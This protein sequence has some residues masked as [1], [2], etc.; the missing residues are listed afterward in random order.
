MKISEKI[1]QYR[2]LVIVI[3]AFI[4]IIFMVYLPGVE[5]D[6]DIKSQLPKDM[7]SRL[8]TDKIDSLFG[9]TELLMVVIQSD[10]ILKPETLQR[11][12]KISNKIKRIKGV[13]KV[14]SL[15]ELKSIKSVDGALL[16]NPAVDYIPHTP[17]EEEQLRKDIK[18]NDIVYG[19]V[20]SKDFTVT[21]VI[22]ML[23][24]HVKDEVLVANFEK[25]ISD[26]PGKEK[27]M[28]GGLPFIRVEIGKQIRRDLRLLMPIGIG[29]MLLF[30]YI[31]FRRLRGVVLPFVVVIM[32]I[33]ISIG[34][35][36]II[37][38]KI[39]MITMIL[40]IL[41]IAVANDYG[42]HMISKY[43]EDNTPGNNYSPKE[44]AER[45]FRSLGKP[46]L[47]TGLT[48]IAGL[49]CLL[50]HILVPAK[51]LGV[52]SAF[53]IFF[54]L[55]ASLFL[56]PAIISLLPRSKPV[57]TSI[58]DTKTKKN[59]LERLL[60][61]FGELVSN[62]PYT[63]IIGA[64]VLVLISVFG[65]FYVVVD[66]NPNGYYHHNHPVVKINNII[67]HYLGGSQNISIVYEGDIKNPE[68]VKKIDRMEQKMAGM[69]EVGTTVS[70]A[71]V[72]R[73]MSRALN[74]PGDAM[75]DK[76]PDTRRAISQYFELYNMSGDPADFEKMVDFPYEHAILTARINMTSTAALNRVVARLKSLVKDD[77]DVMLIG[78]FGVVLSDFA[79]AVVNGQVL[80][81]SLATILVARSCIYPVFGNLSFLYGRIYFCNSSCLLNHRSFR[82]NGIFQHRIKYR[83]GYA[84]FNHDRCRR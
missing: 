32:S 53:G 74:D 68:L 75:Y 23:A 78:G 84:K 59:V 55:I 77:K 7:P 3:F 62:K 76:I 70:I 61:Y 79:H 56:I 44:L 13:E 5:I 57:L 19:N 29:I 26:S 65:I 20:I 64:V 82:I 24:S 66:T 73:Q 34:F 2:W 35:I 18:A 46:I 9:G 37:G 12:Q 17:E 31:C 14:L 10:D 72:I 27:V 4:S 54:A 40:P 38:W 60:W 49:L 80:S 28:V 58:S 69:E 1:I 25:V 67:D 48:T 22:A 36:A 6:T 11:V 15:F 41:L 52:L 45:M 47:L 8:E 30:L 33:I 43:Q 50:G 71:R 16:V 39:H 42:I 51:Q 81:L 63:V 83:N 21:A